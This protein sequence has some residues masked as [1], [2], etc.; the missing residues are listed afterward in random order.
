MKCSCYALLQVVETE[1]SREAL[2]KELSNQ[3]RRLAEFEDQARGV[4][5]DLKM[6]LEE[7]R[8]GERRLEDNRKNLEIQLET[9]NVELQ[10]CVWDTYN[11]LCYTNSRSI[12]RCAVQCLKGELYSAQCQVFAYIHGKVYFIYS[13]IP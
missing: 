10:V 12:E 9:T 11:T 3:Q 1:A 6:A 4:E 8:C 2:R 7:S 13:L 5:K